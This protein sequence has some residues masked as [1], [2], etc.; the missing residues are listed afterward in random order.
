MQQDHPTLTGLVAILAMVAGLMVGLP[1]GPVAADQERTAR[2]GGEDRID[3]AAR[4]AEATFDTSEVAVLARA[5]DFPDALSA[6]GLSGHLSAPTL[7]T[8]RETITQRVKTSLTDL[9]VSRVRIMGGTDAIGQDVQAWLEDNGYETQ[10]V[11]GENRFQ[12]A[13]DAARRIGGAIGT[14]D[15]KRTVIVA[16]GLRFPDALTAGPIAYEQRFPVLL[17]GPGSLHDAAARAIEDVGAQHAILVGGPA[18]LGDRVAQDLGD[19]GLTVER[20]AGRDR[21]DTSRDIADFAVNQLGW[22]SDAILLSRGDAF[23]DALAAAPHGGERHAPILLTRAADILS[24]DV[25]QWTVD[26]AGSIEI[27]RALGRQAAVTDRALGRVAETAVPPERTMTYSVGSRGD[28]SADM[29]FFAEHVDWTLTDQR[30]WALD[31]DVRWTHL[32]DPDAA[33]INIFLATGAAIGAADEGCSPDW[34]C[35]PAGTNDVYINEEHWEHAT[36]TY[37]HRSL[38]DY[39]HYVVLHEVGH[40]PPMDFGHFRCEDDARSDDPAPVMEQQSQQEDVGTECT[41]NVWPLPFE[42]DRAREAMLG[43]STHSSGDVDE[44]HAP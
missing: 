17:T 35:Q 38:D 12:T 6:S 19:R 37:D 4:I 21:T 31:N 27:V 41:I 18:A 30:G 29:A 24:Y 20:L 13:A 7:I 22:V 28:V 32:A 3:T 23:P 39:R 2:I 40:A 11:A 44:T 33:D 43:A 34:S 25:L 9:D 14:F 26:H 8:R 42:R 36:E 5:F 1:A 16:N 10:R 15:G